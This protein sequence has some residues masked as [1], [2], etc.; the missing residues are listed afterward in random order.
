MRRRKRTP[1]R[2]SCRAYSS[3]NPGRC[4]HWRTAGCTCGI[5]ATFCAWTCDGSRNE[6][7][8]LFPQA[9]T[10]EEGV[11]VVAGAGAFGER[12]ELLDVAAAKDDVIREQ[13]GLQT[14]HHVGDSLAPLAFAAPL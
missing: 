1:S 10:A 11:G 4:R 6:H 7:S 12:L 8:P 2:P 5:R 9:E 3:T 14:G 13:C